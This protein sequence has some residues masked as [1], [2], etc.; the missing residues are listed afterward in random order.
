MISD[1]G[2]F[3]YIVYESIHCREEHILNIF[4][5]FLIAYKACNGGFPDV[6][7]GMPNISSCAIVS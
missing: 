3:S 4:Y 5:H 1:T 7:F 2:C 6:G